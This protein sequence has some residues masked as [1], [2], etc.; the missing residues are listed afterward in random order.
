MPYSTA[1]AL[2]VLL[3]S[4]AIAYP[5][6][7][8]TQ[9]ALTLRDLIAISAQDFPGL[10]SVP[11][12]GLTAGG[13]WEHLRRTTAANER[14]NEFFAPDSA[15]HVG[16]YERV[17]GGKG[18]RGFHESSQDW[19]WRV[20]LAP[21]ARLTEI[22][23]S[24]VSETSAT[25]R[26]LTERALAAARQRG[27][28]CETGPRLHPTR[29]DP[30]ATETVCRLRTGITMRFELFPA[31]R[32][33]ALGDDCLAARTRIVLDDDPSHLDERCLADSGA[34]GGVLP[35]RSLSAVA[36]AAARSQA[37]ITNLTPGFGDSTQLVLRAS[38]KHRNF[39]DSAVNQELR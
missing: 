38:H 39:G 24:E 12:Q 9:G 13:L 36:A 20:D 32:R 29:G 22:W 1:V 5:A 30:D 37:T 28:R 26:N 7:P 34:H 16:F 4:S 10:P 14:A 21:S 8:D 17:D 31:C 23:I 2:S 6:S 11:L 25:P 27:E 35:G 33:G 18:L 15:N 19:L 3:S